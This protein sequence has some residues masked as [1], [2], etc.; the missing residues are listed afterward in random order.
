MP[1]EFKLHTTKGTKLFVRESEASIAISFNQTDPM[2][3]VYWQDFAQHYDIMQNF[4]TLTRPELTQ[5][6]T[7]IF[8]LR[9][10]ADKKEINQ[11]W[12]IG[13]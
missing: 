2:V 7:M 6:M 8:E 11:K 4:S 3:M 10:L 12:L 5:I 9:R 1:K 13:K